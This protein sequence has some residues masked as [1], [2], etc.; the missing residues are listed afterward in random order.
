MAMQG[1]SAE[2]QIFL[3]HL[4][5]V[6]L[7]TVCVYFI[8]SF[9]IERR[10]H[11]ASQKLTIQTKL[12]SAEQIE[13]ER[14]ASEVRLMAAVELSDTGVGIIDAQ[15]N[16]IFG[17][18]ALWEIHGIDPNKAN[19]FLGRHWKY[20][21]TPEGQRGIETNVLPALA[22]KER[23]TGISPLKKNNGDLIQAE[24]SIRKLPDGNY[25]GSVRDITEDLRHQQEK[26]DLLKQVMT[27]QKME[28]VGRL[29]RGLVHDFN[30]SLASI[31]GYSE[32]LVQDLPENTQQNTFAKTILH[33]AAQARKLVDQIRS[34]SV[35]RDAAIYSC[36]ILHILKAHLK[37]RTAENNFRIL[38][39]IKIS[40]T[41][42]N[43]SQE[44]VTYV[45]SNLLDN[46]IES[47]SG[48][49][50]VSLTLIDA[51]ESGYLNW[52]KFEDKAESLEIP[53]EISSINSR[54][55]RLIAGRL[56]R[57][58][59]YACLIV[60]DTGV[61][62]PYEVMNHV[63]EPFYSTK[64][65]DEAH[66]L[67]LSAVHGIVRQLHGAMCIDSTEGKGTDVIVL[68]PFA[69]YAEKLQEEKELVGADIPASVL[70][71][72]DHEKVRLMMKEMLTRKGYTVHDFSSPFA[73]LDEL[74]EHSDKF[75]I[76]ITDQ[77]MPEMTGLDL[78]H[79][80][81]HDFPELPILL[82]SGHYSG[83]AEN[84]GEIDGLIPKPVNA[85][86]LHK[87]IQSALRAD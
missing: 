61:G 16:L 70:L 77:S 30:N 19:T 75:Q 9:F 21:Y 5:V 42:V 64:R 73:A 86:L 51:D 3:L 17:N 11:K 14:H 67:G 40:N 36:D 78:A 63:L 2:A 57:N 59:E 7:A 68:L 83:D 41:Q 60:S 49:G 45:I 43:G 32:F 12:E 87:K 85:T 72:D 69:E 52:F 33:S 47:L 15:Q 54:S 82:V 1:N 71:V 18:K 8:F 37:N 38:P 39:E 29:A 20:L 23:W 44:Q 58:T 46:A 76:V 31:I 55:H 28:A 13:K 34:F 53:I 6:C 26:E 62:I 65:A 81:K 27:S 4:A 56:N 84:N 50:T 35:T 10:R 80:I 25:M 74:R 24:I 48:G 66:G 79:E 22:E